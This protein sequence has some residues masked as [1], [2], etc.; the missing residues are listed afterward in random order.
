MWLWLIAARKYLWRRIWRSHTLFL[1]LSLA[2]WKSYKGN[3]EE[4][5]ISNQDIWEKN[6]LKYYFADEL[7]TNSLY[8]QY[9]SNKILKPKLL[10]YFTYKRPD[11]HFTHLSSH[12]SQELEKLRTQNTSLSWKGA[13]KGYA[14]K[15]LSPGLSAF[16][17]LEWFPII[18]LCATDYFS[19][20]QLS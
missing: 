6:I 8:A 7:V 2:F 3:Y 5:A 1:A 4:E 17:L 11:D 18:S 9:I 19:L 14:E 15:A 20:I 16:Q 12:T 13:L 10:F